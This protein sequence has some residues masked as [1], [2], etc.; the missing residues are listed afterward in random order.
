M[1]ANHILFCGLENLNLTTTQKLIGFPCGFKLTQ[2]KEHMHNAKVAGLEHTFGKL[3]WDY[4]MSLPW[5]FVLEISSLL[6]QG[7]IQTINHY[8]QILDVFLQCSWVAA[9]NNANISDAFLIWQ[10]EA[11]INVSTNSFIKRYTAC[12]HAASSRFFGSKEL[13]VWLDA[14]NIFNTSDISVA[15][16]HKTHIVKGLS[17]LSLYFSYIQLAR[18]ASDAA[19]KLMQYCIAFETLFTTSNSELSHTVAERVAI[20]RTRNKSRRVETYGLIKKAYDVRSKI[21]HGLTINNNFAESIGELLINVDEIARQVLTKAI[22]NSRD[23]LDFSDRQ[24]VS[25]Y[26]LDRLMADGR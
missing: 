19:L 18:M 25:A 4:M 7:P 14:F 20:Y 17:P 1:T 23:T 26:F 11:G 24:A 16:P 5:H 9:D 2:D 15:H 12:S 21:S 22:T 8:N 3:T 10:S 6:P 13:S